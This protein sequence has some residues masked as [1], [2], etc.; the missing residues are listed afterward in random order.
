M[1][2]IGE[3]TAAFLMGFFLYAMVEILC[4]G[5]THWTMALTGGTVLFVL[6]HMECT[7]AAP[8]LLKACLGAL[9]VTALEFTVGVI[10]NLI[11]GWHVWD[12]SD[13]QYNLLGQIC[14][15][16]SVLWFLLCI[17]A[18]QICRRLYLQY[19]N[20]IPPQFPIEHAVNTAAE[21]VNG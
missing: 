6:Y 12:Y 10:D 16:F 2:R 18:S 14:L 9:F 15:P 8:R 7:L 4:R 20:G 17:P 5:Y 11:M 13:M 19:H 1:K 3:Y 21:T